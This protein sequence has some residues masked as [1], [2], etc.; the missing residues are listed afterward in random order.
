MSGRCAPVNPC[1]RLY[2]ANVGG[3][4]QFVLVVSY[5]GRAGRVIY[6]PKGSVTLDHP[7]NVPTGFIRVWLIR[8]S[9]SELAAV[10]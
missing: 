5:R 8:F 1:T 2:V 4:R 6:G 3:D 9:L 10:L 7:Y